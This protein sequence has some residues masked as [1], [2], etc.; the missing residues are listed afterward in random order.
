M[1]KREEII[2]DV[3][4][5][6]AQFKTALMPS[7]RANLIAAADLLAALPDNGKILGYRIEAK[8]QPEC[9]HLAES[10]F[11]YSDEIAIPLYAKSTQPVTP[12]E[13]KE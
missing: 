13:G 1:K 12:V 9:F 5:V 2:D 6:A 7:V 8:G 4:A 10:D 11:C 3:R